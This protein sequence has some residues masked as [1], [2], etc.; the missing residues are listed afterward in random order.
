MTFTSVEFVFFFVL[1]VVAFYL[2]PPK[3]RWAIL[4][5][6]SSYFYMAFVPKYI[7]ILLFLVLIDFYFAKKIEVATG[8]SRRAYFIGS[9]V[10]NVGIL[11][12]FKYF[13]FFNANITTLAQFIHWNYSV[14]MLQLILP[15]GLSFHTFQSISY[16]VEVYR[17]NY[18][19][20]RHLGVYALYVFFFP[21]LVAGPI[22]RPQHLLPQ[23]KNLDATTFDTARV[24]SGLRLMAWGFFKKL[25]IADSIA[26]S[27]DYIYGNLAH[28]AGP[29]VL[30]AGVAFAFQLY[31]DFS[32]YTDIARGGAR[33][34][35]VDLMRN[36]N[37][38]YFSQSISEFWR[39]WHISL[40]SWFR[41]Y[42]YIPL[43]GSREGL[44]K[45][46]RNILV[47]FAITGFWHGANWTFIVMGGLYGSYIVIGLLTKEW[48]ERVATQFGLS[49]VPR[50][51]HAL[52]VALTFGLVCISWVF[53]R[54]PDMPTALLFFKRL[55]VGW[56]MSFT[57][58]I[59][60]YMIQPDI[61]LGISRSILMTVTA[62]SIGM[63][64]VEHIE[65]KKPISVWLQE[66]SL[67]ARSFIYTSL[68]L[69]MILFGVFL[70]TS[71]FIYFQF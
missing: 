10:A 38:P 67:V 20:E 59:Y 30:F 34:L 56:H 3:L 42:V 14:S 11:V 51:H 40:S 4:L 22:E 45:H 53:F 6:G 70:A 63:L 55:F 31:A 39:R 24:S 52:Q 43:G 48:R 35:G 41:D 29:S 46:C 28:S 2:C 44:W 9:L 16:I 69:S 1:I 21:Q 26:Q 64:M 66:R 47:V 12:V 27:V 18:K 54:A 19:A 25:V 23:L 36:F 15:L 57:Q 68:V 71:P 65:Q 37:Q 8:P 60:D 50:L 58:Y 5:I 32:G 17:G 61:T 13:N 7:L 49:N 62:F 33:V